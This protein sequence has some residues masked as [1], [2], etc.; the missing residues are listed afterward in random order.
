MD[1]KQILQ[2]MVKTGGIGDVVGKAKSILT[3]VAVLSAYLLGN[4]MMPTPEDIELEKIKQQGQRFKPLSA[5]PYLPSKL[6]Q[7]RL[8]ENMFRKKI[9]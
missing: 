9:L 5:T 8:F 3:P 6:H 1:I 7:K 4:K 2:S